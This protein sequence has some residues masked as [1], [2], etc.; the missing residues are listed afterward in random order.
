MHGQTE[1]WTIALHGGAKRI[2]RDKEQAN[3][4]GCLQALKAG[5]H[6][7]RYGGSAVSAVEVAIRRLEDDGT[8]NAGRGSSRNADGDVE[9]DAALM[10]GGRLDLGGV[11]AIRDVRHPITVA[12]MMLRERPTLLVAD[13]ARRFALAHGVELA[14]FNAGAELNAGG[15]DTVG[16]VA[17]D[18]RGDVAAGTSTGG[19]E[20]CLP[21]RVGDSPL[22]GCGLYADN[23]RGAVCFSGDGEG[24]ARALLAAHAMELLV[25]SPQR[26]M[27]DAMARV[28]RLGYEAGGVA[29]DRA[30]RIGWAHNTAHF[31]V[32]M[33]TS[34]DGRPRIYLHK[35]EEAGP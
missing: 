15:C 22:P 26:A 14:D 25:E 32:A 27:D 19:I 2:A 21:G 20:G 9:M 35:Q 5:L 24:I 4:M 6:V 16:C 34:R 17:L 11:A 1:G 28:Q 10:E 12:R 33:A 7:L 31:A 29:I 8:F 18:A 3:R 13:G 23:E 30:G